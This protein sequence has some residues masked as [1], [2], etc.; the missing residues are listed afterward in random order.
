M[1]LSTLNVY[2]VSYATCDLIWRIECIMR[3]FGYFSVHVSNWWK[4]YMC[5]IVS[6]MVLHI[7]FLSLTTLC[8]NLVSATGCIR[9]SLMRHIEPLIFDCLNI[10]ARGRHNDNSLIMWNENERSAIWSGK[11]NLESEGYEWTQTLPL[12]IGRILDFFNF[13]CFFKKIKMTRTNKTTTWQQTLGTDWSG[14][15]LRIGTYRSYSNVI[16]TDC[17]V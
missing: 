9:Y 10:Q 2:V 6:Y 17:H 4:L 8:L 14:L 12:F 5:G 3:H 15:I 7:N 13:L 11:R 16:D 1:I